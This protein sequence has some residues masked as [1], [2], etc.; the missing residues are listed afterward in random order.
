MRLTVH[1]SIYR[2]ASTLTAMTSSWATGDTDKITILSH[3]LT[4]KGGGKYDWLVVDGNVTLPFACRWP[5]E[6]ISRRSELAK[7]TVSSDPA[8]A[9]AAVQ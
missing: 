4:H 1:D 3:E 6:V 9:P 2:T 7:P 8:G 5:S